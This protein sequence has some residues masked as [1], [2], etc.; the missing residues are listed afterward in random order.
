MLI[1]SLVVY[2]V[3]SG[4]HLAT[5]IPQIMQE[6]SDVFFAVW[7]GINTISLGHAMFEISDVLASVW[8]DLYSFAFDFVVSKIACVSLSIRP[9][10]NSFTLS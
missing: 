5:P 4:D 3:V 8:P 9:R 1:S 2:F 7:P 6:F 10:I